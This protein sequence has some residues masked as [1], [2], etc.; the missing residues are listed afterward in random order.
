MGLLRTW[1][2]RLVV[3]GPSRKRVI[4]ALVDGNGAGAFI[5]GN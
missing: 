5:S 3:L 2:G 1:L 4:Y